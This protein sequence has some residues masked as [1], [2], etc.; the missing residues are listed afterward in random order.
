MDVG[1]INSVLTQKEATVEKDKKSNVGGKTFGEP[2]LSDEAKKYYES[3]KG[4]FSNMEFVLVSS[5][6]K[7]EA[8]AN[9]AQ[10]SNPNKTVVVI[11]EEKIE[12]MATD[13]EYRKKYEGLIAITQTKIP[14][15]K[16]LIGDNINVKTFGVKADDKGKGTYFAVVKKETKKEKEVEKSKEDKDEDEVITA[17]SLE[18][19]LKKLQEYSMKAKADSVETDYEKNFGTVI[20]Y[21]A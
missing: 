17:N 14:D 21:K 19:L 15:V 12:R 7:E 4:R 2:K 16:K 10:F 13:E 11:D 18:E 20:D 6:K 8:K 9:L 5:D 3:L 1:M